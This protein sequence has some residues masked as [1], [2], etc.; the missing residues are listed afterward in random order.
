MTGSVPNTTVLKCP[1]DGCTWEH[2]EPANEVSPEALA[3]MFGFGVMTAV[4]AQQRACRVEDALRS[5]FEGHKAEDFLRTITRQQ[6]VIGEL[7]RAITAM[8][9]TS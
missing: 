9:E 3:G 6:Q 4:A 1:L 7:H 8:S 5:H 2:V